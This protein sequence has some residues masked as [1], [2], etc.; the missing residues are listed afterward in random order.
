MNCFIGKNIEMK[1][2]YDMVNKFSVD[3]IIDMWIKNDKIL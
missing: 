3:V 1:W 2:L